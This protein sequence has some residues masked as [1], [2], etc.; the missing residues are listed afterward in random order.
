MLQASYHLLQTQRIPVFISC[1]QRIN[2]FLL[3]ISTFL[4]LSSAYVHSSFA[5]D[6]LDH[7]RVSPAP[8]P[9]PF[10]SPA[11]A[12]SLSPFSY[13]STNLISNFVSSSNTNTNNTYI[14]GT[15]PT[16]FFLLFALE[17]LHM[18]GVLP[19]LRVHTVVYATLIVALGL[20]FAG[21]AG[22]GALI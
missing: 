2:T 14:L 7:G 21:L 9:P 12:L 13:N 4:L 6:A 1:L 11:S 3:A 19:R 17:M 22:W 5:H 20:F 10:R 15:L 16:L 18:P 8:T